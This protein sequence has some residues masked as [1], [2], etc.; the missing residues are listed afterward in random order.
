MLLAQQFTGATQFQVRFRNLETVRRLL[1]DFEPLPRLVG[2]R[3][4][5]ED[6]KR[7]VLQIPQRMEVFF[8]SMF[9]P[10]SEQRAYG[11]GAGEYRERASMIK[12][13]GET[14]Y[15]H[16]ALWSGPRD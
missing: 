10:G 16:Q 4:G 8:R 12:I 3:T 6:A 7:L 2:L 1:Q 13:L 11:D 5:D 14:P 9:K 15:R